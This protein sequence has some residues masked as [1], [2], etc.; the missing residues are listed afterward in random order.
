MSGDTASLERRQNVARLVLALILVLGFAF[1]WGLFWLV[2]DTS[3]RYQ[4]QEL[5]MAADDA[6]AAL[7][8]RFDAHLANVKAAAS[9]MEAMGDVSSG[10]FSAFVRHE[11]AAMGLAADLAVVH[12]GRPELRDTIWLV[13]AMGAFRSP[14]LAAFRRALLAAV[15]PA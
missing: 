12:S 14:A 10:E 5:E 6:T 4:G 8:L 9:L 7:Q 13:E 2:R 11:L 15:N 1:S 3:G